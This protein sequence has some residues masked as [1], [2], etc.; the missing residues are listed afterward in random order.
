MIRL[1][2]A[3]VLIGCV[4]AAQVLL[5]PTGPSAIRFTFFGTPCLL[6]GIGFYVLARL[7]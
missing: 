7:R 2:A 4:P 5:D 1:A 3:L 6:A